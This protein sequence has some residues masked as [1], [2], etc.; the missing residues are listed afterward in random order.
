VRIRYY[1]SVT[2]VAAAIVLACADLPA[3]G[4]QPAATAAP[5]GAPGAKLALLIGINDYKAE[6][7]ADLHGCVNDVHEMKALLVG[8]FDFH[9]DSIK[10]LTDKEAT[11]ANIIQAF[12]QHLIAKAAA[13]KAATGDQPVVVFHYSGHG[14]Q[15]L[16]TSGDEVDGRDESI[17]P[18]DSAKPEEDLIDD[19]LNELLNEL[20]QITDSVT[21]VL[22]SCH[23]GTATKGDGQPRLVERNLP[24]VTGITVET[25]VD[26]NQAY[27]LITGCRSD[28]RSYEYTDPSGVPHGALTYFLTRELGASPGSEV[29]YRDVLDKVARAVNGVRPQNPQLAGANMDNLVFGSK[30]LIAKPF[31]HVNPKEGKIIVEAGKAQGLTETS[32]LAVYAPGT[33]VFQEPNQP[34]AEI[35]L[36][37]VTAFE[38]TAKLLKGGPVPEAAR[39]VIIQHGMSAT[40]LRLFLDVTGECHDGAVAA[41]SALME[42]IKS[43]IHA[44]LGLRESVR[45]VEAVG[46]AQLKIAVFRDGTIR[47]VGSHI[48]SPPVPTGLQ[49]T[50][51]RVL[52]Q[53]KHWTTWLN[54]T[55]LRNDYGD[56]RVD[57]QVAG[58]D[59]GKDAQ[60]VRQFFAGDE[61]TIT[62]TNKSS[63]PLH[64]AVLGLSDNGEIAQ[65]WPPPGT[66]EALPKDSTWKESTE[67]FLNDGQQQS[68]DYLKLLVFEQFVD[69]FFLTTEAAP[70][71]ADPVLFPFAAA[72]GK[73]PKGVLRVKPDAWVTSRLE[74]KVVRPNP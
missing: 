48:V 53:L 38:S 31:I 42:R 51:P 17:V 36:T 55:E 39:A 37:K 16:D 60:G 59:R 12:R 71:G 56:L 9:P 13:Y 21:Y 50:V 4:K 33:K 18:H 22:D 62:V 24:P 29:T 65:L 25:G 40:P 30:Q 5:A 57:F 44:D 35:E 66:V 54:L 15:V 73:A 11:R 3:V 28:Q 6:D 69:T 49:D 74:L 67:T 43:A 72:V 70:K 47:V 14:G 10:M 8:K 63:K 20:A 26:P 58:P 52:A 27:A 46:E 68:F 34:V 23:A 2:F 61:I 32:V 64:F 19:Q 41:D 1:V 45:H 7:I